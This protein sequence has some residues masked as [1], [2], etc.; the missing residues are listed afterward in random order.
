MEKTK[1]LTLRGLPLPCGCAPALAAP[2]L[3]LMAAGLAACGSSVPGNTPA[4]VG[5]ASAPEI[6]VLSNRPDLV[7]GDDALVEIVLPAGSDV[8][9]LKV[10]REGRDISAQFALRPNG[11]VM[12]LVSGLALGANT[13][14]ASTAGG[15]SSLTVVNHP[16]GGPIFAGPQKLPWPCLAGATDAQCNRPVSYAFKYKSS[17]PVECTA[18]AGTPTT[19]CF[20]PY[21]PK[22]PPASVPMT[23]T[24]QGKTLPYIVRVET[25][26][27]DRGQYQFAVLFD[28]TQEWAPWA[29]QAGWNGKIVN[30]GGSGCGMHH[31]ES[32]APGEMMDDT[33]LARGYLTWSTALSHNTLNCNLVVQG[34]SLMMAKERIVEQ[35]GPIRYSIGR[36]SSG[37]SIKQQQAA[38]AYPGIFDGILPEASFPDTWSTMQEVS[39]CGLMLRY[40]TSPQSWAP[41]VVWTETQ[42]AAVAGH[43]SMSV[44][45]SWVATFLQTIQPR[46]AAADPT[47]GS[48]S[49]NVSASEAY[50][51][52]TNPGGLRCALQDYMPSILGLR[53]EASWNAIEKALGRGFANRPLDNVGVQYGLEAFKAGTISTAQFLDLNAK[54]GA[55]D[56][57]LDWQPAR[58]V[59]DQGA[60]AVAYRSGLINQATNM[61]LPILDLRLYDPAEIHH[62]YRSFVMRAR[63]ER[64][65]GHHENQ[66]IWVTTFGDGLAAM[67]RWLA[68]IEA[69]R[70]STPYALKVIRNRPADV[71][72]QCTEQ[73]PREACP[74]LYPS[75]ASPRIVAGQPFADDWVKCELKAP[76]AADYAPVRFTDA[77]WARLKGLFPAG[78]CDFSKPAVGQEPSLPWL[79]YRGGVG[80]QP[81]PA[82]ATAE[83]WASESLR[84]R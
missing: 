41:G 27:Q 19:A 28:P 37:G 52:E 14:R 65:H 75:D 55:Y 53:P 81:L 79:D 74:L 21:D 16:N 63:L 39:D 84:G 34:E 31:G 7:S 2:L 25:G 6:K 42:N 8:S 40:W 50:D 43:Q 23:T 38:N 64:A 59:A 61:T 67:D 30:F 83:G 3:M 15:S 71:H 70:S 47:G 68:A 44:C 78:V 35:Y 62:T 18:A 77:E 72:D 33:A 5:T 32:G 49:C 82:A 1:P 57:D 11:R 24:D 46:S 36:G 20:L 9:A 66:V 26:A 76:Q 56:L 17:N 51:P 69:D 10:D 29:P 58:V 54:I 48:Q 80:G 12:G 22:K 4:P 45:A 13:L 73:V 60:L